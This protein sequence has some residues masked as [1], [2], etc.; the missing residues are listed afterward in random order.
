MIELNPVT[1]S[2]VELA[3]DAAKMR[4]DVT[5]NN[6]ANVNTPNFRAMDVSFES[7]LEMHRSAMLDKRNDSSNLAILNQTKPEVVTSVDDLGLD[8]EVLVDQQLMELSKTVLHYKALLEVNNKRGSLV[9][10]AITGSTR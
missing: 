4:L 7:Q 1:S 3:L 9:R 6:V 5:A 10:M 8:K 2:L